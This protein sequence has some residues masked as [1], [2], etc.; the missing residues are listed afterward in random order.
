ML[1][2]LL[3]YNWIANDHIA[4][5]KQIRHDLRSLSFTFLYVRP[6]ACLFTHWTSQLWSYR[7]AN[8]YL[9][10]ICLYKKMISTPSFRKNIKADFSGDWTIATA[11]LL[12]PMWPPSSKQSKSLV[13]YPVTS[14]FH[15]RIH[16][17]QKIKQFE[18]LSIF[19]FV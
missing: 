14:I 12:I 8:P 9:C 16:K 18:C 11:S 15:A 4:W 1:K 3:L 17:D 10:L 2:S 19:Y 7:L 6:S 5:R 13:E